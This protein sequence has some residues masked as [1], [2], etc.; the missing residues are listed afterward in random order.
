MGKVCNEERKKRERERRRKHSQALVWVPD[1]TH[2]SSLSFHEQVW[3]QFLSLATSRTLIN[4]AVIYW[5]YTMEST[6]KNFP[7]TCIFNP[8]NHSAKN[9]S[10]CILKKMNMLRLYEEIPCPRSARLKPKSVEDLNR[11]YRWDLGLLFCGSFPSGI[12][13]DF[14]SCGSSARKNTGFSVGSSSCS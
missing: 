11:L 6:V 5:V 8:H 4:S 13:P 3:V 9:I 14:L 1:S 12:S 10:F 2:Y 7:H